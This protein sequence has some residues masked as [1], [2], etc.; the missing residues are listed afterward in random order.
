MTKT[1]IEDQ[2][3]EYRRKTLFHVLEVEMGLS[4]NAAAVKSG[5]PV[6]SLRKFKKGQNRSL[7]LATY[8][9]LAKGLGTTVA[10]LQ[11]IDEPSVSS[12]EETP[13]HTEEPSSKIPTTVTSDNPVR[14]FPELLHNIVMGIDAM[15]QIEGLSYT[16]EKFAELVVGYYE[17]FVREI[18]ENSREFNP[19]SP[20]EVMVAVGKMHK[21]DKNKEKQSD[22]T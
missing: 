17:R 13:P 18:D 10:R 21:E 15:R 20:V 22:N 7:N 4:L 6:N 16:P 5:V 3:A 8:E 12:S 11:G 19:G 9:K 1:Q 2:Q 14:Y